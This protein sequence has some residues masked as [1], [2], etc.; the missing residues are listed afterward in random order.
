MPHKALNFRWRDG[1]AVQNVKQGEL[2][3]EGAEDSGHQAVN[4]AAEPGWFRFKLP[5]DA[6]LGNAGTPNSFGALDQDA[7]YSNTLAAAEPNSLPGGDPA[8]PI[9]TARPG[10]ATR[11]HM[12]VPFATD[13]DSTLHIAGHVWQRDPFVCTGAART[14]TPVGNI[15]LPVIQDPQ[16]PGVAL[17]GRCSPRAEAPSNALGL[18][19]QAKWMG[20]EEGMGHAYGHWPIL[21]NAGGSDAANLGCTA[22]QPCDFLYKAWESWG[23]VNGMW[24]LLRVAP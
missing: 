11:I 7:Y 9:F 23:N 6:P 2:G 19:P 17:P 14:Q 12:L 4:Y 22:G 24:G 21:V 10:Q 18:N 1:T 3:R 13:R 5:P 20:G 15:G 8:T 16:D